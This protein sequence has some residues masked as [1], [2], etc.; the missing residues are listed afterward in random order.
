MLTCW[1]FDSNQPKRTFSL[2]VI[3][4]AVV[5]CIEHADR[6]LSNTL[7]YRTSY[8]PQVRQRLFGTT[9][10]LYQPVDEN[11]NVAPLCDAMTSHE[12]TSSL[13]VTRSSFAVALLLTLANYATC[14]VSVVASYQDVSQLI[15]TQYNRIDINDLQTLCSKH[16]TSN[17]SPPP[18]TRR[19]RRLSRTIGQTSLDASA[20]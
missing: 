19:T 13:S 3:R 4:E 9:L 1:H 11:S 18:R 2:V 17:P 6:L 12:K 10:T 14:R 7:Y 5:P 15:E 8:G 16:L 20:V